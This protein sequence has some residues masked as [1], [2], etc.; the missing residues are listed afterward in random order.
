MN[1]WN[2]NQSSPEQLKK[3]IT[4]LQKLVFLIY[5]KL[6]QEERQAIFDQL[7]NSFDPEDKDISMLI[8]SYRI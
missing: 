5:S 1:N 2:N 6:P 4:R 8:N 7:S 3:E